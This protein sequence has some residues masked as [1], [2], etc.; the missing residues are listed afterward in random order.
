MSRTN[1]SEAELPDIIDAAPS[2][3]KRLLGRRMLTRIIVT[4]HLINTDEA[5]VAQDQRSFTKW[6]IRS[7]LLSGLATI[8]ASAVLMPTDVEPTFALTL[9]S[10]AVMLTG[11]A[12]QW[13][14]HGPMYQ[15]AT[16]VIA[17][18]G[19]KNNKGTA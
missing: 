12:L 14:H 18:I 3:L 2:W 5:L 7:V 16:K 19:A 6:V 13:P 17:R 15:E 9:L 1:C 10:H 4:G 8:I 11:F